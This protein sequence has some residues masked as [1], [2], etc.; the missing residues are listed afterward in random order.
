MLA[1]LLPAVALAQALSETEIV[2]LYQAGTP[3]SRLVERIQRDGLTFVMDADALDRLGEARVSR[4]VLDA[5]TEARLNTG[6]D[7][8]DLIRRGRFETAAE[9]LAAMLARNPRDHAARY[10]LILIDVRTNHT[11]EAAAEYQTMKRYED[12]DAQSMVQRLQSILPEVTGDPAEEVRR[13]DELKKALEGFDTSAA[14]AAVDKLHMDSRSKE[15][16]R[17]YLDLYKADFPSAL[18]RVAGLS[19]SDDKDRR[20]AA[21]TLRQE[22]ERSFA[23]YGKVTREIETYQRSELAMG[24]FTPTTARVEAGETKFSVH[25]YVK[26][27]IDGNRL[28]PLDPRMQDLRFHAVLVSSPAYEDVARVGDE[29]MRSKG[30]IHI[31]FYARDA[32]F[33][34]VID[35]RR[36]RVYTE[37]AREPHRNEFGT[38]DLEPFRPFDLSFD[39]IRAVKQKM[40][41]DHALYGLAKGSYFM[42]FEPAGMEAP[43]YMFMSLIH[44][45][46][47]EEI[48]RAVSRNLADFILHTIGNSSIQAS[49]VDPAKKSRD[50]MAF[51]AP[52]IAYASIA[53]SIGAPVV[54]LAKG[55]PKTLNSDGTTSSNS[56]TTAST[57][58]MMQMSGEM[59]QTS[60]GILEAHAVELVRTAQILGAPEDNR[61]MMGILRTR[62]FPLVDPTVSPDGMVRVENLISLAVRNQGAP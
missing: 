44:C 58:A 47:G 59:I 8:D 45:L 55:P 32:V 6:V 36:R 20:H 16:V 40:S 26:A 28:F 5:A 38:A 19:R 13:R 53:I 48:Q 15:I 18:L 43:N 41:P 17:T 12:P 30:S 9:T 61:T 34:L 50:W 37:F 27:V 62:A 10:K 14:Y 49:L 2:R 60:L 31:P 1:M 29:V 25:Q 7:P 35:A 52:E 4:A 39:E 57:L 3:E 23:D 33:S 54:A 24:S 56:N 42:R 51:G 46:Y 21:E 22:V 11:V